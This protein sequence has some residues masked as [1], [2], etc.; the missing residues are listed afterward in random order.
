LESWLYPRLYELEERHWWFRGRRAV[1]RALLDRGG[2]PA[3][4]RLL[5]AGCGT[6]R[7][8]AELAPHAASAHGV[9]SAGEAVEFCRRRG[10]DGVTE[11][12]LEVLPFEDGAFDVL[13]ATD[14]I[15]HLDDDL[16]ALC[17][18]RRVAAPGARLLLTVPA[19]QW[20]WSAHDEAHQHRRRY[21]R[22]QL[23]GRVRAA[24]WEPLVA[25]YFNAL[26]LGPIAVARRLPG[27]AG[28]SDYDRT[29]RWLNAVLERPMRLE[30]QLIRR[31][32]ALP[33]GVSIGLIARAG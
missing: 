4:P 18:L 5:D 13:L 32:T 28:S 8:L 2:A 23:V 16:A 15:E 7:N 19:Y 25:T 6:G 30:A 14:V 11:A 17:E 29:P 27:G 1:I 33:A 21:T 9:D 24:G 31:G 20:L 3:R 22:P 10:L 26:L 12:V